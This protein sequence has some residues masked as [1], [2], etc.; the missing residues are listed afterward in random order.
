MNRLPY[1]A[2][3]VVIAVVI[4]I[5]NVPYTTETITIPERTY[6]ADSLLKRG[7]MLLASDSLQDAEHALKRALEYYPDFAL[8]HYYLAEVARRRG[9]V[10]NAKN[11]FAQAITVDPEFY[12]AY[13]SLAILMRDEGAHARAISLLETA[14]ILN[15]YYTDA[16]NELA[17]LYIETGD[18]AAAD[19]VYQRL[20]TVE[21]H[22]AE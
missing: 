10:V 13:Y 17:R 19:Q 12:P 2:S 4:I 5:T 22:M 11:E 6:P 14:I 3:F 16:Y 8:L 20:R 1:L 18:F 7:I 9:N 21:E 15:P